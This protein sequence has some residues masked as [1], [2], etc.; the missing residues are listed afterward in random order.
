VSRV[1]ADVREMRLV[2]P[3][4]ALFRVSLMLSLITNIYKYMYITMPS[5]FIAGI[6]SVLL[7][8]NRSRSRN[9]EIRPRGSICDP[10]VACDD[11]ST[12]TAF[13]SLS[14]RETTTRC[15]HDDVFRNETWPHVE[16]RPGII[17]ESSLQFENLAF[18]FR[19]FDA[20]LL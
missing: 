7:T 17:D 18:E 15:L 20:L 8:A 10:I 6:R 5:V 11:C 13:T 1:L 16:P 2:R 4:R 14:I 12:R 9:R 19:G 3:F